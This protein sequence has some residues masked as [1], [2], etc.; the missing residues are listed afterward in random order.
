[1]ENNFLNNLQLYRG[2][3]FSDLVDEN[4][5]SSALLTRPHEVASVI[6]YVF[7]AKDSDYGSTIDFLTG[8]LGK[9]MII[10]N[11]QYEWNVLIDTD[12]AIDIRWAK[13]NGSAIT[14]ANASTVTPGLGNTPIL[15]AL[16]DKWFGAG[17]IIEF[18]NKEYQ[19]RIQGTPYQDGNDWVYT[20]FLAD[21]QAG[22]FVPGEYLLAGRQV[23]RLGSA[24]EEYSD[25]AD[26]INYN[27]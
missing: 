18:D 23:S 12:R 8:G 19:V 1:M 14:T 6:S 20:V 4:M 21:G 3:W 15:L 5:L 9:T 26:I 17:A 10:D 25:E 13:W 24:Y 11:R 7:G 2:K 22:S 16:A 27:T